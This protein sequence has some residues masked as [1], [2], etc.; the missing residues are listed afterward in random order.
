MLIRPNSAIVTMCA[1]AF[2][3]APVLAD[4]AF[5]GAPPDATHPWAVHDMNRPQPP[6]VTPG[7]FSSDAQP[8]QP[9]SDAI[10]LFDGT[11]AS[12]DK[13]EADKSPAE[14]TKWVV[15]DGVLQCVPGSGYIRTKALF[16]DCQLHVEW[17]APTKIEGSSQG[18]GNSG[19]FLMGETE[20]QVLNNYDNPTYADGFA[21]SVYGVNPPYA[22]ALHAPGK[23]QIYDI[24][25]RRP[26]FSD[27]KLLDGGH[28]TV[29]LNGVVVQDATP[30]EGGG[31]HMNRSHDHP[32]VEKGPLKLQDHGNP[33]RYRN[34][35]LRP[36]PPRAID[37]G[38]MGAM[39]P[40]AAT[41]KKAALATSIRSDAAKLQG[42]AK[43]LRLMES[44]CYEQDPAT[45]K[46]ALDG[47]TTWLTAVR[48]APAA[49]IQSQKGEILQ[50][51]DALK[52]LMRFK[53]LPDGFM[54]LPEIDKVIKD[55]GWEKK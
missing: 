14:P 9:P 26:I 47:I 15:Q 1:F 43:L 13:W 33:V 16:A 25:F 40:A 51:R 35:W 20:I 41:A 6:Q 7:T 46:T 29:L 5:Y 31:G 45:T 55:N 12:L 36:L 48:K 27:G 18:R 2:T 52:Y 23:W 34:I 11:A 22:N 24:I 8:G 30:L 4:S 19:I 3:A 37:G 49:A 38:D 53:F 17:A 42:Q 28:F 44:L 10:V 39:P 54:A 32:F 21:G 50:M